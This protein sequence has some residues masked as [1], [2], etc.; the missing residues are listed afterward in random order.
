MAFLLLFLVGAA[1]ILAMISV[2]RGTGPAVLS[3]L[4]A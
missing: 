2:W 1:I 4:A 3:A